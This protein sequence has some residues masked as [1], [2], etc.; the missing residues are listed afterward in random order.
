MM[1]DLLSGVAMPAHAGKADLRTR[2]PR[3]LKLTCVHAFNVSL[4]TVLAHRRVSIE[5][6]PRDHNHNAAFALDGL[7]DASTLSRE[8][9]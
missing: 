9:I 5:V 2:K 1:P 6:V 4:E 8:V 3:L 7:A